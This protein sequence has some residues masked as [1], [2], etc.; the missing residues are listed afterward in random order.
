MGCNHISSTPWDTLPPLGSEEGEG[1]PT[2]PQ[3]PSVGQAPG[4]EEPFGKGQR[5]KDAAGYHAHLVGTEGGKV[6]SDGAD[7]QCQDQEAAVDGGGT[8]LLGGLAPARP[9]AVPRAVSD[10]GGGQLPARLKSPVQ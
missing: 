8:I 7:A 5:E 3:Q 9:T 2:G 10:G 6:G 1:R 4:R